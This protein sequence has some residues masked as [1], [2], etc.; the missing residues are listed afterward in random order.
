MNGA[1]SSIVTRASGS[2]EVADART[3]LSARSLAAHSAGVDHLFSASRSPNSSPCA[4]L[5]PQRLR[6]CSHC[7]NPPSK[8][9]L[10]IRGMFIVQN[11][12]KSV[13]ACAIGTLLNSIRACTSATA[14][15][16]YPAKCSI[17]TMS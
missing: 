7:A 5:G 3:A 10:P 1:T 8:S 17:A 14:R 13:R 2:H 9:A 12:A 15:S 6:A 16:S 11:R 4:S